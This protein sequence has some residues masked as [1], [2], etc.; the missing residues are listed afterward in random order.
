MA[1]TVRESHV[2]RL[3]LRVEH[4]MILNR[5]SRVVK[6]LVLDSIQLKKVASQRGLPPSFRYLSIEKLKDGIS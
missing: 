5:S 4:I 2:C 6:L 1:D 3:D